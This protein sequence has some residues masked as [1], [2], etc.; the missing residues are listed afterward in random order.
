MIKVAVSFDFIAII[1]EHEKRERMR[2]LYFFIGTEAE[3]M[4]VYPVI[5]KAR[6]QG[7][8]CFIISNGQN[9][10]SSSP[11][12]R[13]ANDGKIDLDISK[14][15]PLKRTIPGYLKWIIRTIP[16][17]MP[18][19]KQFIGKG[20][21]KL[22]VV[23]GDTL[24]TAMGSF[25]ARRLRI[26]YVHIESGL[27]SFNFLS[28]FPEEF[29]RLYSSKASEINF[30]PGSAYAEYADRAFKGKAVD[31]VYNTGI[32]T[33]LDAIEKNKTSG[34][35]IPYQGKYFMFM[36]HRQENL[37]HKSFIEKTVK[38]IAALSD[39][40]HCIFIYHARTKEVM[41]EIG[42]FNLLK[43]HPN[44]T[45]LSL[46]TYENFISLVD[47]SE[48]VITDG[49]GNQQEF[50]YMG[51]P[52]LI[53]RTEVEKNSE[54]LGWNAK[55]FAND[56]KNIGRFLDE[57]VEYTKPPVQASELPSDII[58]RELDDYFRERRIK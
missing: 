57:Y 44:V 7:Y 41:E 33:L 18:K 8:A 19:I 51:K 56:F 45:T 11:F 22:L 30:C 52:Y 48:F 40:M 42:V 34:F 35:E 6:K 29:D 1:F 31:T 28:P 50:Y 3:L 13:I 54:G 46:Q 58:L 49:C 36:L 9:D 25:I 10:I 27:R 38:E 32:E 15:K 5:L 12:L 37:I 4:K 43:D 53:M 47:K 20:D 14:Y 24:S 26:K 39:K 2:E 17:A 23:H 21:N 55:V 16:Y